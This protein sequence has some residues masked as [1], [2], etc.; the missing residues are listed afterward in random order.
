MTWGL[1][2]VSSSPAGDPSPGKPRK[3][4]DEPPNAISV[5][6]SHRPPCDRVWD[7]RLEGKS[8]IQAIKTALNAGYRLIDTAQSYGNEEEVGQA[9][10][11]SGFPREEIFITTK[12][13]DE[14]K[15]TRRP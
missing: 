10:V 6:R 14:N 8:G 2:G 4:L 11:E 15:A 12:I 13:T 7:E 5:E 1:S 9:I 3:E